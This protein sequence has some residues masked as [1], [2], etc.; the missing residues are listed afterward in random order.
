MYVKRIIVIVLDGVG[1]GEAPD[2]DIY[3]DVGSNSVANTARVL[4]GLNLPNLEKMGLGCVTEVIGVPCLSQTIGAYGKMQPQSAGKD[5]VSGHWAL[6][7]IHLPN[8]FPV[9]RDGFPSEIIDTFIKRSGVEG[10]LGNK[11]ASGTVIIQELGLK[12]METGW[13]IVYTSADSVFQIAAHEKVIPIERLYELCEVAREILTG[14]HAVGRVIARP[15]LGDSP[16]SFW[17]TERRRDYPL[18]PHSKTMMDKLVEARKSVY[19]V[20]KI[21][22]IFGGR[23]IS[24]SNHTVNN[25]DSIHALLEFLGED[26][27]GLLFANL[28]EFDMIYGHRNDPR[29]YGQALEQFDQAIP[30]IRQ[31]M[32]KTDVVIITSDHGIDPTTPSTDH[33]REN[34]PLLV[35]GDPVAEGINLGIRS[36]Y[37]DVAATIAELFMLEPPETGNSFWNEVKR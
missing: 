2:A 7:G 36:T 18:E 23:G 22:D 1:V 34:I 29:G 31:R 21:D 24:K 35:F 19:T 15:F 30:E 25:Q 16:G 37:C 13:P 10:I 32:K 4:G 33:S 27:E 11:V 8:P 3:G 14:P 20:G 6:M 9:Y 28:I 17:R 26:F 5:T 12:H